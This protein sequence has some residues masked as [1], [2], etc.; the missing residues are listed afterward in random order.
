MK[1]LAATC[2]AEWLGFVTGY[3]SLLGGVGGEG[4]G[5][6]GGRQGRGEGGSLL[7]RL[8]FGIAKDSEAVTAPLT[9][10]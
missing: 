4:G 9:W 7:A 10:M 8:D 5:G 3:C 6:E 2:A 1:V